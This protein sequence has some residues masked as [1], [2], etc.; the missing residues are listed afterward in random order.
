MSNRENLR[1][2]AALSLVIAFGMSGAAGLASEEGTGEI[3]TPAAQ[4]VYIGYTPSTLDVVD[5]KLHQYSKDITISAEEKSATFN[6]AK[7]WEFIVLSE[8]GD[9]ELATTVTLNGAK[10]DETNDSYAL[11]FAGAGTYT[12][13][14]SADGVE[15]TI[16]I[17]FNVTKDQKPEEEKQLTVSYDDLKPGALFEKTVDPNTFKY[18]DN[19]KLDNG[20]ATAEF[21]KFWTFKLG[22]DKITDFELPAE[23]TLADADFDLYSASLRSRL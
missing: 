16:T 4:S 22:N 8:T 19:L 11:T 15:D 20:T 21:A 1:R 9:K 17:T 7:E 3:V 23:L 18:S 14:I 5:A 10:I 2:I 6:L 13:V 12:V